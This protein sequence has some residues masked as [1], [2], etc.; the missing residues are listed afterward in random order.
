MKTKISFNCI[1]TLGSVIFLILLT[2]CNS[3]SGKMTDENSYKILFLRHSTGGVIWKGESGFLYKIK[4]ILGA[5]YAVPQWFNKY[6]E[7]NGT[8]YNIAEQSF[9]KD[10]PY[11][12]QNYPFDYYNIWV[13]NAGDKHYKEE[14]TLEI[15]TKEYDFIIFKHC[16]PVSRIE[17]DNGNPDINSKEKRIENYKLQYIA[18]KEKMLQFPEQNQFDNRSFSDSIEKF[19]ELF[20]DAVRIRL[21]ADVE[22]AAY[23]SGGIDSSVTTAFIKKIEPE[24]LNTFS[25]G[26]TDKVFDETN[27]QLE[28]AKYF[29][30]NHVAFSCTS[31]EIGENFINTVIHAEF[32]ILRT[33]P[34][35]MYLLSKKVREHNIKVV[36]TGEGADEMFAGYNIFKE[37]KIRR[38]WAREPQSTIRPLLLTKLYPYLP[39]MKNAKSSILKMFFGYKLNETDN[40]FYSHLLR[41]NNT[42]R[43]MNYFS[44]DLKSEISDYNPLQEVENNLKAEYSGWGDLSKS[45]YLEATIFMSGYLLSSQGDRMAMAN[46]VEGRYPFLDHRIIE[47]GASLP[48]DYKLHGLNEKY[49]LKEMMKGKIPESILKRSKQAYRAPIHTSFFGK[50]SPEYVNNLLS[51]T[52]L[53]SFTLFD[54][55]KVTKLIDKFKTGRNISEVDNMALAGILSTQII[56]HLFI[57]NSPIDYR[58]NQLANL[59][60]IRE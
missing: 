33:A 29:N 56:N 35:P 50:N 17:K 2:Q 22:V 9:P 36:I 15:L 19:R 20:E 21:R 37:A 49:I 46:S 38:F 41:W 43:I 27:Y 12:W 58:E 52:S 40:P 30:T 59:K 18:L 53:K 39:M 60:I 51:E 28:A 16:F 7:S 14:S 48:D 11:G 32:P 34:T 6:N 10:K 1:I 23:L 5:D 45:Q 54:S 4:H 47:F 3:K 24:V 42:S 8:N 31:D 13:K 25:I 57:N 44:E 26:F 55:G